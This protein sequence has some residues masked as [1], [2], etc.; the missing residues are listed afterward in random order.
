MERIKHS[1]A[2]LQVCDALIGQQ[3]KS[4]QAATGGSI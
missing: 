2:V 4:R 3:L 1:R